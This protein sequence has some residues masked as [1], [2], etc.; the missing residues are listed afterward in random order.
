MV[1]A[2]VLE[3]AELVAASI[4]MS[5]LSFRKFSALVG[6]VPQRHPSRQGLLVTAKPDFVLDSSA[7]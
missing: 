4:Y 7:A 6:F 2:L 5:E 1:I 3:K